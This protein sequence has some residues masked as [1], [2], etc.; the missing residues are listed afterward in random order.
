MSARERVAARERAYNKG[1]RSFLQGKSI[2]N[3]PYKV[4]T[5]GNGIEW[6]MGWFA[7]RDS[8]KKDAVRVRQ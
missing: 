7:A 1:G 6:R 2:E 3:N 8:A 4:S 5:W